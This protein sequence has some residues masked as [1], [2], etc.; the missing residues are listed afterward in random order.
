MPALPIN[1][2]RTWT[3]AHH[4]T[5]AKLEMPVPEN[6][7][8]TK[9]VLLAAPD[10]VLWAGVGHRASIPNRGG[11]MRSLDGGAT[12]ARADMGFRDASEQSYRVNGLK[13]SRM[14]VLYAATERGVWR[15]TA[16]V[17]AAE[18]VPVE[19][20]GVVVSV[21]PNP[22]GGRVKVVVSLAAAQAVRV[23]VVD[24]L[25]REVTVVLDEAAV[26]ERVVGLD[27]GSWPAGV[28]VVRATAGVQVAS[29][30]LVVAR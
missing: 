30:R 19:A 15:T 29:A 11:V 4:F 9:V 20:S 8:V 3:P 2:G 25:G 5:A 21:R 18:A 1:G 12:W 10:G 16:T 23:V 26:G 28:Y 13:L 6:A 27:T 24:A 22:A 7:D 17:V 14:G